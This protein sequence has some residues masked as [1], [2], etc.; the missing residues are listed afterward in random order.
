MADS[1]IGETFLNFSLE[2]RCACLAGVDLNHYG[3]K[4]EVAGKAE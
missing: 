2:E 3:T 1:D 4:F